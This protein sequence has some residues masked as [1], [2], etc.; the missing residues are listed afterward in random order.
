M[1]YK[2]LFIGVAT[3]TAALALGG[4]IAFALWNVTGTGS[5]AGAGTTVVT[6]T[7]TPETPAGANANMFPGG[8]PGAVY[9]E[10]TNPNPFPVSLTG[11][12]WSTPTSTNTGECASTNVSIDA[13]APTT[14]SAVTVAA[15]ATSPLL[16]VPGVL[17]LAPTA[18]TGCQGVAFD[19]VLT[20]TGTQQP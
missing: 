9:F 14:M 19:V 16:S 6:L 7:V 5:G 17:D 3:A 11:L 18:G 4:G 10:V 8:P 2:K 20:V 15:N 1:R 13:S 12:N